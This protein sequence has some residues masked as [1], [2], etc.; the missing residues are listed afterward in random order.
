L[1][2]NRIT[3]GDHTYGANNIIIGSWGNDE[4]I[5]INIGKYCSIA[6]D[7]TIFIS[8]EHQTSWITTFPFSVLNGKYKD[9]T[10]NSRPSKG[11]ITIGNDVWICAGTKILSGITIG[12]GA[13]LGAYSVIT[14]DVPPYAIVGGNPAQIIRY[15]FGE[16]GIKKLLEIKWW[17]KTPEEIDRLMPYLLSDNIEEFIKGEI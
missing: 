1:I 2:D 14:K 7:I 8:G 3:V 15:R 10:K 13:V 5:K 12:D 9:Y 4:N 6:D 17:N 16:V 11:N